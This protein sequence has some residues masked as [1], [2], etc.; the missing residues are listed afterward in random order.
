MGTG[1]S[2]I[3]LAGHYKLTWKSSESWINIYLT[4]KHIELAKGT[5]FECSFTM[6]A[7]LPERGYILQHG[8]L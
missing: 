3:H 6:K 1:L 7:T 4:K 8:R 5:D 2:R